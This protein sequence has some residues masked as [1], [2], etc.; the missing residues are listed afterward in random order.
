M[1]ANIPAP[2]LEVY[3]LVKSYGGR[4]V[5]D[6]LNLKLPP[7]SLVGLLGPNGAGK[8]TLLKALCGLI[9]PDSGVIKVCGKDMRTE[10]AAVR[11][12][13]AYV[14]DVPHF[15]VE[16]SVIEHLELIARAHKAMDTF[17]EQ[18]EKLL[19]SFGLW[20]ARFNPSFA[21]SRGMTQKLAI[22]GAFIRPSQVLLL[23]E[24][25]GTLDIRSVS[26][27]YEMLDQYRANG[28]LAVFSSH[29]WE[30]LQNLCDLFVLIDEGQV[31][32]VGDLDFL[33]EGADLPADAGLREVYMAFTENEYYAEDETTATEEEPASDSPKVEEQAG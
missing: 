9:S 33:R 16:L 19:R 13:L 6:K 18:S 29:Q 5:L 10:E 23:D 8:T 1:T 14:P 4:R 17:E 32:A 22:C 28:G 15:Y 21:L 25:G 2:A 12:N 27:L 7:A 24:P 30:T 11:S 26:R 31:V 3:E 20:E